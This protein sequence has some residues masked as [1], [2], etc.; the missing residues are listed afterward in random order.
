MVRAI[1]AGVH[2]HWRI[3]GASDFIYFDERPDL[4][5]YGPKQRPSAFFDTVIWA[6]FPEP[7]ADRRL[8]E[9]LAALGFPERPLIWLVTPSSTPAD[10]G[11]RLL[12][13]DFVLRTDLPGMAVRLD[14]VRPEEPPPGLEIEVVS[15]LERLTALNSVTSAGFGMPP[16]LADLFLR[17]YSSIPFDDP[18]W[19]PY[20][21]LLDG[22]VVASTILMHD[23]DAAGLYAVAVLPECQRRGIGGALTLRALADARDRGVSLVTLRASDAGASM[24]ARIGFREF[25]R[26]RQY[27]HFPP[28]VQ[29]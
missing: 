15:D 16:G 4:I 11:E 26:I 19:V 14:E 23:G 7:G 5:T 1:E 20:V 22:E 21:G 12:R 18:R 27:W 2:L 17:A 29:T 28:G 9:T 13:R 25:C 10:L 3:L 6:R 8:D 24:Y